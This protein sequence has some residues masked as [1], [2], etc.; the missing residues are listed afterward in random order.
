M[1]NLDDLFRRSQRTVRPAT[2]PDGQWERIRAGVKDAPKKNRPLGF[3]WGIASGL[4]MGLLISIAYGVETP[5]AVPVPSAL[6]TD[7]I[8]PAAPPAEMVAVPQVITVYDTV[9]VI[10]YERVAAPPPPAVDLGRV[11]AYAKAFTSDATDTI[12]VAKEVPPLGPV[13]EVEIN[14][15]PP[16]LTSL[17]PL[18]LPANPSLRD[19]PTKLETR[20]VVPA[21][22]GWKGFTRVEQPDVPRGRWEFGVHTAFSLRSGDTYGGIYGSKGDPIF[23]RGFYSI[24]G[25]EVEMFEK[26]NAR[27][28]IGIRPRFSS[29][30]VQ[31]ARQLS[32][33][34]RLSFGLNLLD[35]SVGSPSRREIEEEVDFGEYFVYTADATKEEAFVLGAGYTFARRKRFQFTTGLQVIAY[36]SRNR[37]E[38]EYAYS[39][40]DRKYYPQ[41]SRNIRTVA[42]NRFGVLPQLSLHYHLND[43]LS[44]GTEIVPGLGLGARYKLY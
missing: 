19:L 6:L 39:L 17:H 25:R 9:T 26:D 14:G 36:F 16:S 11:A 34:I 18:L 7:S 43:R 22:L 27:V 2:P 31:L 32:S 12:A 10:V 33:G 4:L 15:L 1:A 24:D 42:I 21:A 28:I 8:A 35:N 37:I 5:G 29:V 20:K 3:W 41:A 30:N 23:S 44:L 38:R 13:A 40:L